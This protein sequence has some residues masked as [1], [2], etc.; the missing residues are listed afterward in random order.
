M[1]KEAYAILYELDWWCPLTD[2]RGFEDQL[3]VEV[4]ENHKL[5]GVD[6]FAI[7]KSLINDDVLF[8]STNKFYLVHLN[9]S[10]GDEK[11]PV[12]EEFEHQDDLINYLVISNINSYKENVEAI[13][14]YEI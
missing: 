6:L 5:F 10:V 3:K 7:G 13:D 11:F 9:W 8:I 14:Y 2:G 4:V 1:I 12:F